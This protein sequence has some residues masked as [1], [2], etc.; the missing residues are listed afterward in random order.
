LSGHNPNSRVSDDTAALSGYNLKAP[1]FAGGYL[2]PLAW[3]VGG[4][5]LGLLTAA[6][7]HD[8]RDCAQ[9]IHRYNCGMIVAAVC[10]R[11]ASLET[12]A[13]ALCIANPRA[14]DESAMLFIPCC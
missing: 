10:N 13:R 3:V 4:L 7:D 1:G 11:D 6:C 2:L 9:Q 12:M 8:A 5:S 14:N